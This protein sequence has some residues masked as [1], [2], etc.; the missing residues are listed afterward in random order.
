MTAIAER[1]IGAVATRTPPV[2]S[3]LQGK[4][5]RTFLGNVGGF[6][7]DK[8][9]AYGGVG[10]VFLADEAKVA[11]DIG[12]TPDCFRAMGGMEGV[13]TPRGEM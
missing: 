1:L 13:Y 6:H 4:S 8:Y 2:G 7:L 5:I 9:T 10:F 12:N 3:S 11:V